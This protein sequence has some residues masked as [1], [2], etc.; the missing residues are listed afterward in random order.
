M[1]I[2]NAS[3]AYT[4]ALEA[5]KN[6]SDSE[7]ISL[8]ESLGAMLPGNAWTEWLDKRMELSEEDDA[9]DIRLA[10]EALAEYKADPSTA[11]D[12]ETFFKQMREKYARK[13][14]TAVV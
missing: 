2:I 1:Y 13:E 3:A 5:A 6:L 8:L 12:G 9:E 14:E 7:K 10:E 11:V 4:Q